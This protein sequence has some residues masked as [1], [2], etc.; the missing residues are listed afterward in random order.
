METG[1]GQYQTHTTATVT[2]QGKVNASMFYM[3]HALEQSV[4]DIYAQAGKLMFALGIWKDPKKKEP[5]KEKWKEEKEGEKDN[6]AVTEVL[7]QP[8][9]FIAGQL[10]HLMNGQDDFQ[11]EE[12]I[13]LAK[14][15]NDF[16]AQED[17]GFQYTNYLKIIKEDFQQGETNTDLT[18]TP[19]YCEKIRQYIMSNCFPIGL[20]AK[21]THEYRA[22]FSKA[23]SDV[24]LFSDFTEVERQLSKLYTQIM[25]D[26]I[27]QYGEAKTIVITQELS[28][29]AKHEYER[30]CNYTGKGVMRGPSSIS[31]IQ[32][33]VFCNDEIAGIVLELWNQLPEHPYQDFQGPQYQIKKVFGQYQGEAEVSLDWDEKS[34]SYRATIAENLM[35]FQ[36]KVSDPYIKKQINAMRQI[37]NRGDL[38]ANLEELLS[39][40]FKQQLD[41][42]LTEKKGGVACTLLLGEEKLKKTSPDQLAEE[43]ARMMMYLDEAGKQKNKGEAKNAKTKQ[44][45]DTALQALLK[46]GIGY[47]DGF[48]HKVEWNKKLAVALASIQREAIQTLDQDKIKRCTVKDVMKEADIEWSK[49]QERIV[50]RYLNGSKKTSGLVFNTEDGYT[51]RAKDL[52]SA[53][54]KTSGGSA[55]NKS[56]QKKCWWNKKNYS[57]HQIIGFIRNILA[58]YGKE[59]NLSANKIRL[60]L[61]EDYG[62]GNVRKN[63]EGKYVYEG[64]AR[65]TVDEYRKL[66]VG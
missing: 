26:L 64:I 6:E 66:M 56:K 49:S 42:E 51:F 35:K 36:E 31:G 28:N 40:D 16:S 52:M 21:N 50:A 46:V 44:K 22:V 61:I 27:I 62:L 15:I 5:E 57:R 25:T 23:L 48:S 8:L 12:I 17:I 13:C 59:K 34:S 11:E 32:K 58:E 10:N 37:V 30:A 55:K 7:L 45:K 65:K 41:K 4:W 20:G 3:N 29:V 53:S 43:T 60:R 47:F 18:K 39:S 2:V 63:S 54:G 19:E 14:C 24:E 33:I 38:F 9:D 1:I